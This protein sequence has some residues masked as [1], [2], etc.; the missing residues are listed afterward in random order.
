MSRKRSVVLGVEGTNAFAG[1]SGEPAGGEPVVS[2]VGASPESLNMVAPPVFEPQ[3]NDI[4]VQ[5]FEQARSEV[6]QDNGAL[7]SRRSQE[8]AAGL[9]SQR[10]LA[11]AQPVQPDFSDFLP[12]I[13]STLGT[14]DMSSIFG[15]QSGFLG[16]LTPEQWNAPPGQLQASWPTPTATPVEKPAGLPDAASLVAS[17]TAQ[18]APLAPS[19]DWLGLPGLGPSP[20]LPTFL[21]LVKSGGRSDPLA[22]YAHYVVDMSP[23]CFVLV[24]DMRGIS[25]DLDSVLRALPQGPTTLEI[26]ELDSEFKP[27]EPVLAVDML[28]TVLAYRLGCLLHISCFLVS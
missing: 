23:D 4:Y 8:I 28:P 24:Q 15:S 20:K 6:G 3:Y 26:R 2:G 14:P 25:G 27:G 1:P 10:K 18:P 11:E 22:F 13:P 19:G 17:S 5:A 21:V 16:Q 9:I 7:L 12:P